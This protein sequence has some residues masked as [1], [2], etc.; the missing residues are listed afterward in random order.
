MPIDDEQLDDLLRDVSVPRDLKATLLE[1]PDREPEAPFVSKHTHVRSA[2]VGTL[3]AI[4]ATILIF[5]Y[6]VPSKVANVESQVDDDAMIAMLSTEM[7]ENQDMIDE[8]GKALDLAVG[9]RASVNAAPLLDPDETLALALSMSWQS[10]IEQGASVESVQ[11][12][13]ES[14]VARYPNTQGA[15]RARELLTIN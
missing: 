12:E 14:V 10:S 8:I 13:L 2:I 4:A 3:L 15:Q 1:I 11:D 7:Q 9:E 5:L 6:V